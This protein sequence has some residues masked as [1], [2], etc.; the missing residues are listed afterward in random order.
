MLYKDTNSFFLH[1]F[2]DYL[3]TEINPRP[4]LRDAFDFSEISPGHL[5]NLGRAGGEL[6]LGEMGYF[7]NETIG[8]PI[9]EFVRLRPKMYSFIV[10]EASEPISG[11]NY[12][13]GCAA[14]GGNIC[15]GALPNQTLQAN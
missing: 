1:F 3:A 9:V 8:N 7:K 6:H 5:F 11:L 15:G 14:Q 13:H 12:P 4:Q 2:V 10:C